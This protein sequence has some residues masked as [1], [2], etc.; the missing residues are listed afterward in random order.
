MW[1]PLAG[2][3]NKATSPSMQLYGEGKLQGVSSKSLYQAER[4]A[5]EAFDG[6]WVRFLPFIVV[7]P[8]GPWP[9]PSSQFSRNAGGRWDTMCRVGS[10]SVELASFAGLL[11]GDLEASRGG[12][13]RGDPEAVGTRFSTACAWSLWARNSEAGVDLAAGSTQ[14]APHSLG[15]SCVQ[16]FAGWRPGLGSPWHLDADRRALAA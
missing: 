16:R 8:P 7:G 12:S 14:H 5:S 15:L 11:H 9:R 6:T 10:A 3:A 1:I 13:A 2:V 4:P